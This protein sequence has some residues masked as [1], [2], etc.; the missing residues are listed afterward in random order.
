MKREKET[1][2]QKRNET[3]IGEIK[4]GKQAD[5]KPKKKKREN[6]AARNI[7]R[8][9][10]E[11]EYKLQQNRQKAN[12]GE[13]LFSRGCLAMYVSYYRAQVLLS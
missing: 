9:I 1:R 12:I 8:N 10:V 5:Q 13:C 7:K 2:Q 3:A 4:I 11:H 6:D